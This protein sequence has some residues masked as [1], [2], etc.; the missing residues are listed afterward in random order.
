MRP[1][2]E[3]SLYTV[4]LVIYLSARPRAAVGDAD[5]PAGG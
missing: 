4:E 3:I 1:E 5:G 2:L